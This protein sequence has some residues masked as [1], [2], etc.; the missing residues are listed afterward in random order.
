MV[1]GIPAIGEVICVD[2]GSSDGTSALIAAG[3]PAVKLVRIR[4]NR[5]KSAAVRAGCQQV[6]KQYVLLLDADLRGLKAHEINDV[7]HT[8]S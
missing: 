5:G 1:S 4:R 7:Q 3:F 2:D 6:T 8:F